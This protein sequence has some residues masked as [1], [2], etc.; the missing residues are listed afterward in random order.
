MLCKLKALTYLAVVL[1]EIITI[2]WLSAS[3]DVSG[4]VLFKRSGE[5]DG[6]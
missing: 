1:Y 4:E 6:G 2:A 5:M 3:I